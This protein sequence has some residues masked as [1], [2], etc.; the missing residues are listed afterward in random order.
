MLL[1]G[2]ITFISVFAFVSSGKL[3]KIFPSHLISSQ[4]GQ[5]HFSNIQVYIQRIRPFHV[6]FSKYERKAKSGEIN[7][8]LQIMPYLIQDVPACFL[9]VF[10]TCTNE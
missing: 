5:F 3:A 8:L 9:C 4:Y 7:P 6:S 2:V 1:F 10:Q